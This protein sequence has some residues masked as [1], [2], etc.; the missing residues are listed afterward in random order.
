MAQG[1]GDEI[2]CLSINCSHKIPV[3]KLQ[4]DNLEC[5]GETVVHKDSNVQCLKASFEFS[6]KDVLRLSYV[7]TFHSCQSKE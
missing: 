4:L 7:I 5:T 3:E 1:S 2:E 6:F